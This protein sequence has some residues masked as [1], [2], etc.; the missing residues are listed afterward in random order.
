VRRFGRHLSANVVSYIALFFAL[1]G[2]SVAAVQALP[3]NSV[4]SPQ[5]RNGAIQRVDLAKKTVAQLRGARGPAG[6]PGAQGQAGAPGTPGAT[7][8]PGP[9]TGP[10][11]G[12][13]TGSYPNPTIAAGA[14][15]NAKL[16]P[17][18]AWRDVGTAGQPA[19]GSGWSNSGGGFEEV[20]FRKGR[21]GVVYLR[22]GGA[23]TSDTTGSAMFTL[24][25]G[26]RP[27]KY[28]WFPV[29]SQNT[30]SSTFVAGGVALDTNGDVFVLAVADD[31][32]VSLS[33]ISFS[34][35]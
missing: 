12:D 1:G 19:F 29:A 34:T 4:G 27:A 22:G 15:T 20:S 23:K 33:G 31:R 9:S 24:P 11:G 16:S 35:P 13:L 10:A 14:V 18:E 3:R 8:P 26:Y 21:D 6:A 30:A 5:I 28:E 7:G 2:T 32:F 17:E 25:A